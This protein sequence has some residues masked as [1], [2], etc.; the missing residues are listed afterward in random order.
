MMLR[1]VTTVS[2]ENWLEKQIT[3]PRLDELKTL[4]VRLRNLCVNKC[5]DDSDVC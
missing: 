4:E 5:F 1:P 2:P 3:R